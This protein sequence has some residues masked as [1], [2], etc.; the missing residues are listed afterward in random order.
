MEE[1]EDV[2]PTLRE[3]ISE[4]LGN[5]VDHLLHL[6]QIQVDIIK[7]PKEMLGF[8]I[9]ATGLEKRGEVREGVE[10]EDFR[11]G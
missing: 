11:N 1:V 9:R 6:L 8:Q 3:E 10:G 5:Q 7:H 4:V 2:D